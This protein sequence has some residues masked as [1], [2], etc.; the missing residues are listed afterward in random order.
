VYGR[1]FCT[2][3]LSECPCSALKSQRLSTRPQHDLQCTPSSIMERAACEE[4]CMQALRALINDLLHLRTLLVVPGHCTE[5]E[6]SLS[7]IVPSSPK[8]AFVYEPSPQKHLVLCPCCSSHHL[9]FSRYFHL[10]LLHRPSRNSSC[11]TCKLPFEPLRTSLCTTTALYHNVCRQDIFITCLEQA[12][13][14]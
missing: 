5:S 8:A 12:G 3:R 4:M 7:S 14:G 11:S 10:S 9:P 13:H 2:V 6:G 1:S